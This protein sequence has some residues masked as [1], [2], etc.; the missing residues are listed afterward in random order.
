MKLHT[1][2]SQPPPQSFE[3]KVQAACNPEQFLLPFKR[4]VISLYRE[5][6][7]RAVDFMAGAE[8][9]LLFKRDGAKQV[10]ALYDDGFSG[11]LYARVADILKLPAEDRWYW[12]S[13]LDTSKRFLDHEY[14][15]YNYSGTNKILS[16]L[17]TAEHTFLQLQDLLHI[18]RVQHSLAN[19]KRSTDWLP[20]NYLPHSLHRIIVLLTCILVDAWQVDILSKLPSSDEGQSLTLLKK[21][22]V[23]LFGEDQETC[24]RQMAALAILV[25]LRD[26]FSHD[27]GD[28]RNPGFNIRM[29]LL[30]IGLLLPKSEHLDCAHKIK[31]EVPDL[32]EA[33]LADKEREGDNFQA[34]LDSSDK[35][36]D[37]SNAEK[38]RR[39][40]EQFWQLLFSELVVRLEPSIKYIA[41]F[42]L[43]LLKAAE[44]AV[45]GKVSTQHKAIAAVQAAQQKAT[46]ANLEAQQA[47]KDA[48]AKARAAASETAAATDATVKVTLKVTTATSALAAAATA[49][50]ADAKAKR[51]A[52]NKAQATADEAKKGVP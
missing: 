38:M 17:N 3:S 27:L 36:L 41:K 42:H 52:A 5:E 21:A 50:K 43:R 24:D 39:Q 35:Q 23:Q 37:F 7:C 45:A 13:Q 16:L 28:P 8:G 44:D 19:A 2:T 1:G 29:I 33:I 14:R 30:R 25:L 9:S 6:S 46:A 20:M 48:K 47:E 40:S 11:P 34:F 12:L 10:L 22:M 15:I 26:Y 32:Y 4:T 51:T 49:A 18:D 31:T